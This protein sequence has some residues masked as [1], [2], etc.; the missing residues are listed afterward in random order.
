MCC[1]RRAL[2]EALPPPTPLL[3]HFHT[4]ILILILCYLPSLLQERGIKIIYL[5]LLR[6]FGSF[7]LLR[8]KPTI[9]SFSVFFIVFHPLGEQQNCGESQLRA[10]NQAAAAHAHFAAPQPPHISKNMTILYASSETADNA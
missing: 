4:V 8:F 10:A 5:C 2:L 9:P 1:R 6:S 3:R 7:S